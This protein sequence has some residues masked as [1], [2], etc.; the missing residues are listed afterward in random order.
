LE[1]S[2]FSKVEKATKEALEKAG[3]K[4]VGKSYS[5]G[6]TRKAVGR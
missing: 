1:E 4:E 5:Q 3:W 2:E 6:D